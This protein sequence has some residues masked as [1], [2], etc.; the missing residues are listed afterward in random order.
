[1]MHHDVGVLRWIVEVFGTTWA[2]KAIGRKL[3]S[4]WDKLDGGHPSRR[5]ERPA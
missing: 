3:V 5:S 4:G 1:M 2:T